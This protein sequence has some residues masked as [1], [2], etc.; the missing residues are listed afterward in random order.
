MWRW[1]QA[2]PFGNDPADENPSGLGA[3]DLPLRLPGQYA[4]KETNLHYNYYRDFDPS[5]G[6][7]K[8]SDLI[9]L[10]GGLNTY[11][12]AA[13]PLSQ[14]DPL[15]LMGFGG[16]G[17]S[18]GT[19]RSVPKPPSSGGPPNMNIFGCIVGCLKSPIFE[20]GEPQ[21]S[22][23]PTIGGGIEI[24]E[25]PTKPKSCRP[26]KP[27]GGC[28]IYDPNCD[29]TWQW[30][31]L[32]IPPKVGFLIGVSIKRDGKVCFQFGL[33]GSVPILPSYDLGDA[34]EK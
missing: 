12:Y 7:Y 27:V 3:F 25:S 34:Y 2:E 16:G 11:A 1:D 10:Q 15:G 22:L 28:G 14:I 33:F 20:N 32:P 8:Q 23:E 13:D 31:G 19:S 29:N 4:D 5:L 6:I 26:P 30:P 24:C 9:G 21:A 17:A 18:G